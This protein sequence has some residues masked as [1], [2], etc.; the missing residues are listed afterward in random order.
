LTYV[1]GTALLAVGLVMVQ[2]AYS[3]WT[4]EYFPNLSVK[5]QSG[6]ELRFFDDVL[7]GK[8]VVISFVYTS[9]GDICPL[10]TARLAMVQE[11]LTAMGRSDIRFIS[12]TVDPEN[13]TPEKL[14][15]FAEGMNAGPGWMFITG[16][17]ENVRAIN[18]KLGE[19]ST[20]PRNHRMEIVLGNA[21][22]GEWARNSALG[23]LDR[24]VFDILQMDPAWRNQKRSIARDDDANAIAAIP[25]QQGEGLFRKLCVACHT[26]GVGKRIGP[27]LRDVTQRRDEKWLNRFIMNPDRMLKSR[28][29][30]AVQLDAAFPT[31]TMPA[32]GLTKRDTAD[33]ISY[34]K[35]SSAMLTDDIQDAPHS[36]DHHATELHDH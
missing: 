25:E 32:L 5:D 11:K 13:D 24:L 29:P 16:T 31:A 27:D 10:S 17:P 12:M 19:R 35:A 15:A 8:V 34:L 23:E 9:C 30:L 28:D 2:P 18:A 26:I 36:H 20:N 14:S 22:T 21:T 4:G 6:R 3:D 7:K 33:L 1:I